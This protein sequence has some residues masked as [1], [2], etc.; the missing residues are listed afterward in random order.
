MY[1]K[2]IK[3]IAM[4]MVIALTMAAFFATDVGAASKT[5]LQQEINKLEQESKELDSEI[6]SLQG[7][8]DKQQQL[9]NTIEKKMANVQSQIDACN[10]QISVINSKISAN[11]AEIAKNNNTN[12]AYSAARYMPETDDYRNST[13]YIGRKGEICG[14]YDKNHLVIGENTNSKIAYGKKA[15][16]II[17]NA[18][19]LAG[20]AYWI[21]SHYELSGEATVGKQDPLTLHIKEW[22]DREYAD[23]RQTSISTGELEEAIE[24]YTREHTVKGF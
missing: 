5:Q 21:N 6:K 2:Y 11:K 13:V 7:K 1:K 17:N 19:G 3:P 8:I 4:I 24:A 15:D 20:I 12:I 22:I 9:K 14:I 23:G 18:S 10:R 16:V